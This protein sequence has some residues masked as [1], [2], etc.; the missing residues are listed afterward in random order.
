M[1]KLINILYSCAAGLEQAF[2]TYET[3]QSVRANTSHDALPASVAKQP[4]GFQKNI[5][6]AS[7]E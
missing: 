2:V 4:I 1:R 6:T 5:V 7:N 3:I